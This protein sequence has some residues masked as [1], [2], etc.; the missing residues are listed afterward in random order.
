MDLCVS[1]WWP[2]SSETTLPNSDDVVDYVRIRLSEKRPRRALEEK[3]RGLGAE[4]QRRKPKKRE[5]K[6][7]GG[8]AEEEEGEKS[9]RDEDSDRNDEEEEEGDRKEESEREE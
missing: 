1:V 5:K 8:D 6:K 7:K 2:L 4:I 9:D 3:L